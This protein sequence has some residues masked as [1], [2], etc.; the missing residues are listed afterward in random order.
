MS[1]AIRFVIR[2]LF[3]VLVVL[4]VL[5]LSAGNVLA[6]TKAYHYQSID[7]DIKILENS[8]LVISEKLT[9]A[10]TSGEFHYGYRWISTDR[11]E[12][13]DSVEVWEGERRYE[14][15]PA[16]RKWIDTRRERGGSPGGDNYAYYTW[17]HKNQLWVAW[18][19]PRTE[20]AR[21]TIE[22]RY[23]VHG[24][25]GIGATTDRLYWQ[26]IF[27]DR[28]TFVSSSRVT[29]HLPEPIPIDRLSIQTYGVPAVRKM[30]D[31]STVQFITGRVPAGEELGI[32]ISFPHGIVDGVVPAWQI[33]LEKQEA[34]NTKVKPVINLA[35]TLLGL[36]VVPL[37]G[38]IWIRRAF[39]RRGP[40]PR[41]GEVPGSQYASPS[42]LSPAFV[43]LLVYGKVRPADLVAT[44]FHL[45]HRRVLEIVETERRRWFGTEK[46]ILVVKAEDGEK[47]RFERLV[48]ET[49]SSRE[50]KLFSRQK[51]ELLE[52]FQEFSDMVEQEAVGQGLFEEEPS[53]S[54]NRLR[55]PGLATAIAAAALFIPLFVFWG[56][57]AEMMFV[58]FAMFGLVGI[59]AV[60]SASRL[61][62]RTEIGAM[63]TLQW[64]AFG[65]YL[66]RMVKDR[67][68][69]I[70]GLDYWD[71][72]FPYAVVFGLSR[73][74]VKQFSNLEAR[75]PAWFYVG[76]YAGGSASFGGISVSAP[77]LSSIAGAFN[78]MVSMV[79]SGF[80]SGSGGGGGGG[81]AG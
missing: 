40:V 2:V 60:L 8:D 47:F 75:A 44:I 39:A 78:G 73:S 25:L 49:L 52:L 77:S 16:V 28:D 7:V 53:K 4:A 58:P 32:D 35:L 26:A 57:Y 61:A 54:V 15:N 19:F 12:S 24:A 62:K 27:G 79:Q 9:F 43:G 34:Y 31:D 69:A 42:D 80:S 76:S 18:W 56:H 46:D 51:R 17:V 36:I 67:Q 10:F 6:D 64:K 22:L 3:P 20:N 33:K 37:I 5:A 72:Y 65:K 70:S 21:R 50:G 38:A 14:L 41:V 68:L 30:I 66:K 13:I 11:V 45:A 63:E 29:V 71:S 81:G 59:A 1:R 23:R 74:W 48:T 55:F